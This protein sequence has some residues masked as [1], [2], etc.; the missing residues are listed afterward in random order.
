MI[1]RGTISV[2]P[3]HLQA[4]VRVDEICGTAINYESALSL[5]AFSSPLLGTS[6]TKRAD[7]G[8]KMENINHMRGLCGQPDIPDNTPRKTVEA[9]PAY[10]LCCGSEMYIEDC[11]SEG[12]QRLSMY[13]LFCPECP[14]PGT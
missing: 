9:Q 7:R 13:W 8:G 5:L 11:T 2:E 3:L 1:E 4:L 12:M 14:G 10:C 6:P